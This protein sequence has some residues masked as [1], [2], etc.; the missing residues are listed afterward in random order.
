MTEE[1]KVETIESIKLFFR[2]TEQ[3]E[4]NGAFIFWSFWTWNSP[5][6]LIQD[7]EMLKKHYMFHNT[8][9]NQSVSLLQ[10]SEMF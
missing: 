4:N 10:N 7:S 1:A 9:C 6:S 2:Y 8:T 3:K 5:K